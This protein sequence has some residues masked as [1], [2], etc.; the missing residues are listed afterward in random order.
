MDHKIIVFSL[1]SA[2]I[3]TFDALKVLVQK[4]CRIFSI[5]PKASS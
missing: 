1:L 3:K 5:K 2:E 4:A